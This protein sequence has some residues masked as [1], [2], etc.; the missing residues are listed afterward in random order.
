MKLKVD[1]NL[2]IGCGA[3]EAACKKCFRI[4]DEEGVAEVI[5]KE[6]PKELEEKAIDAKE[7]CPAQAIIEVND[8]IE[9]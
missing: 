6:I 8:K 2:C 5:V 4:N 7:G 3:C 1:E 9:N